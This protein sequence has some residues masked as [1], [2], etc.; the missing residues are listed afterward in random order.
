MGFDPALFIGEQPLDSSLLCSICIGVFDQPTSACPSGHFYCSDCLRQTKT[1]ANQNV[2]S[3][4]PE[5]RAPMMATQVLNR[6]LNNMI[7][8]KQVQ[9]C[10]VTAAAKTQRLTEAGGAITTLGGRCQ[11]RGTLSQ[12]V[13]SN[14]AQVC[15]HRMVQCTLAGCKERL[16]FSE[17]EGHKTVCPHRLTKCPACVSVRWDILF[18]GV[19]ISML[20]ICNILSSSAYYRSEIH[21]S[22]K[23]MYLPHPYYK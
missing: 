4:C 15:P 17:L 21:V 2:R 6:P 3:K 14:H 5:C 8:S 1:A 18:V 12:Y 13:A 22:H 7:T 16:V 23:Y 9:C 11:W 19:F 10:N 20:C